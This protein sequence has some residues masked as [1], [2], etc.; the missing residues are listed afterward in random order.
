NG[1]SGSRASAGVRGWRRGRD[2]NPRAGVTGQ[3]FSR[4]PHPTALPPLRIDIVPAPGGCVGPAGS[5]RRPRLAR[6]AAAPDHTR[7]PEVA[8]TIS[9]SPLCRGMV[10]LCL[11]TAM[12]GVAGQ[13][14][15]PTAPLAHPADFA[16]EQGRWEDAIEGYRELLAE[17]PEDRLSLLRIAQAERELGRHD[18]ALETLE[19]A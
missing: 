4:P 18:A 15:E 17:Y 7:S 3:R 19:A 1:R 2:S 9:E 14:D 5:I 12:A 13:E 8:M 11:M 16:F 6:V 10:L